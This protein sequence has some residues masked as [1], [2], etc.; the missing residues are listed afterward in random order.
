MSGTV[1]VP[2]KTYKTETWGRLDCWSNESVEVVAY[3]VRKIDHQYSFMGSGHRMRLYRLSH[4]PHFKLPPR[5]I[6]FA[7][8]APA[9]APAAPARPVIVSDHGKKNRNR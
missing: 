4:N 6:D 3:D 2:L 8:I 7:N 1:S 9:Q 5:Y